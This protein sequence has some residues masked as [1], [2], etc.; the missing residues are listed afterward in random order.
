MATVN[1]VKH[2]PE[3][4]PSYE[5]DSFDE[6][7]SHDQDQTGEELP[8]EGGYGDADVYVFRSFSRQRIHNTL[9]STRPFP[10]DPDAPEETHQ[11][12][13]RSA[14]FVTRHRFT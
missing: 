5:P 9:Y 1:E 7:A 4:A 6:K 13:V 10:I 8:M 2:T 14:H 11:L 3:K 12:T